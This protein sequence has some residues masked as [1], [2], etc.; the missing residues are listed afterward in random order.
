MA[1][2]GNESNVKTAAEIVAGLVKEVPVYQ[3]ALQPAARQI[4]KSLEVVTKTINIV[5]APIKGLVWGYEQIESWLIRSLGEKLAGVPP[6]NIIPP[7]P[8]IAVPAIEALRY[9]AYDEQLRE[10]YANLLA[11]AM[12]KDTAPQAHPGYV[13]VLKNL[14]ADEALL[15]QWFKAHSAHPVIHIKGETTPDTFILHRRFH[16]RLPEDLPVLHPALLA[17]Y[18]DNAIRLGL[19]E[20]PAGE[21]L[22]DDR[23]YIP[24]ETDPALDPLSGEITGQGQVILFDRAMIRLTSFGG[25]FVTQVIK[26]KERT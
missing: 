22:N 2:T 21:S 23:L 14:S 7:L 4:G 26:E 11:G 9:V 20:S 18:V 10:L 16:F 8:N 15:L 19:L 5:L 1:A 13:E 17:A 3:D 24:L 12:N 6:E 25:Q